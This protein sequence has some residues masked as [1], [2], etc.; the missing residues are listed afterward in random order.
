MRVDAEI[1][2]ENHHISLHDYQSAEKRF[3]VMM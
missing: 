2:H 3:C 1:V